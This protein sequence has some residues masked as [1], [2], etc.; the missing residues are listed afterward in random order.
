MSL[1][2]PH[3]FHPYPPPSISTG[4]RLSQLC[5]KLGTF[6]LLFPPYQHKALWSAGTSELSRLLKLLL[7]RSRGCLEAE[8]SLAFR[9]R[10]FQVSPKSFK[11]SHK[12]AIGPW[13][14]LCFLVPKMGIMLGETN[15]EPREGTLIVSSIK[16]LPWNLRTKHRKTVLSPKP[17]NKQKL[18][19]STRGQKETVI[20]V[21]KCSPFQ[22]W[23][24]GSWTQF[25]K[26]CL[27][28]EG[29]GAGNGWMVSDP[30][31]YLETQRHL[32]F[33]LCKKSWGQ[34]DF[35][36]FLGSSIIKSLSNTTT[37]IKV[38]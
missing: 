12:S 1:R 3:P 33:P 32:G 22:S 29:V 19:T 14:S 23:P 34:G 5:I 38:P 8:M 21:P 7:K 28:R 4:W 24:R 9:L 35:P 18:W 2:P 17:T 6:W 11:L 26:F 15:T 10:Y 30:A 13:V 25:G 36:I 27:T 37:Y 16:E 31:G 20:T